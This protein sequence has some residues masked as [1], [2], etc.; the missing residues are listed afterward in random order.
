MS[1]EA[2]LVI[3]IPMALS[4]LVSASVTKALVKTLDSRLIRIENLLDSI[5]TK[6]L[7]GDN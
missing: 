2:V 4:L 3:G 6:K 5:M 1:V 7:N